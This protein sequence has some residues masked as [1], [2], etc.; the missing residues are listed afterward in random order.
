VRI[1]GFT[2]DS[3][4]QPNVPDFLF[5]GT[6]HGEDLSS[7]YGEDRYRSAS[8]RGLIEILH[9]FKFTVAEN[10]P[11]EEEVAL[12]PELLGRV[13]ENLLAAYNPETG[14]TARKQTGS[15]YTPREIVD[16]MVDE[17]LLGYL[18]SN[19]DS[20]RPAADVER[21]LRV[22]FAYNEQPNPFSIAETRHLV[23]AIQS[24]VL[25]DPAC[26][27]GAFPMGALLKLV[28][29]LGR[30]DPKNELWR[31]EQQRAAKAITSPE[32][33]REALAAIERA[34]A[35][36]DDDYGRKLYL[37]ENCL[38][39]VDIQPIAV[40]IT[41]LRFFISLIV[42]QE[43]VE[44]EE[45]R[46]ILALPNLETKFVAANS[47][48][49]VERSRGSA[50]LGLSLH[51]KDF[52]R[53][54][55]ELKDIRRRHVTARS[56]SEKKKLR[57]E[58]RRVSKE[59]GSLLHEQGG[60]SIES[61][62]M[63]VK[64]DPYDQNA[65]APFFDPEWMFNMTGGFDV[66]I[67]NPPYLR[68]Q[69][70]QL[71]QPAF[72]PLYKQRFE[73]ATGSFDLYALFIERGYSLLKPTGRLAYIVPHKF[74]QAGFGESLR[75]LLTKRQALT[76]IVRFGTEQVFEEATTYTCLLF[77]SAER[78]KE[79]YLAEVNSLDRG[80]EMLLALGNREAHEDYSFQQFPAP[81]TTRWD[82]SIG[83]S[84][85]ILR[86]LMQHNESLS[87]ITRKIF[88]GLQTSLDKLYVLEI[89]ARRGTTYSCRCKFDDSNVEIEEGLVRPFLMG[90][91]VHRYAVPEPK[92]VVIFPYVLNEG[93]AS[94]MSQAY[95][96]KNYP[97]GWRFLK[98]HE[99]AL[100]DRE[101]GKMAGDSFYA[102]IYPKN[103]SEFEIEKI[104]TPDICGRPEMAL[105]ESGTLYHTT[106]LYSF[107]F[108]GRY[109][110]S[111]R[112]LLGLLNSKVLWYFLSV[113][114]TP[115]RGGYLRFKTEYLR[116]FP[117]PDSSP[118]QQK[119]VETL[120]SYVLALRK[121]PQ[122][123]SD[124]RQ[125]MAASFFEQLIDALVYELY[126]PEE[127]SEKGGPSLFT[128]LGSET[129]DP[130]RISTGKI[131]NVFEKL[132]AAENPVRKRLF[133]LDSSE[134]VQVIESKSRENHQD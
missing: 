67:G 52:D 44:T 69:G 48:I 122:Q 62:E 118:Q 121:R 109:K 17:V 1:D 3:S 22:I 106:T 2:D 56:W 16:Y 31:A 4:K 91:D 86:R 87:K 21:E 134:T 7:D 9:S 64:W 88:V 60:F 92:H 75:S 26:G 90:R 132:F 33:R 124:E 30:L 58:D 74:F 13:F 66:C 126:F 41:K 40:Q 55:A 23:E 19:L 11:V 96:K 15:F 120:V 108:N 94:L 84:D 112:F 125:R 10:T 5:F 54:E 6:P 47:L 32:T 117:V 101:R 116:P 89:V 14:I 123:T 36:D 71:T 130:G 99:Q 50:Q 51:I 76:Q 80:Q 128:I 20:S 114:G 42:N 103:L 73:S 102:Y 34:F 18:Q 61:A 133:F 65:S 100:A 113:T 82:F 25:L 35:R 46:G 104:M 27:S 79:F 119:I 77:L 78:S 129:L 45:N 81:T 29:V 110:A 115:L 70:M 43:S 97:K 85:R 93:R 68:V 105:D 24:I 57:S 72:V 49:S 8:V 107:A 95:I 59:L 63:L 37:I 131:L 111:T 12:D 28:H 38:Y 39:G 98:K 83:A 53:L 127:L